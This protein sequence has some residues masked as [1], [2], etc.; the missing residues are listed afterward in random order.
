MKLLRPFSFLLVILLTVATLS[1]CDSAL[2]ATPADQVPRSQA[3]AS[4]RNA[5][6][7]LFGAY[8]ALQFSGVYGGPGYYAADFTT[9]NL[10]F[11]G[12]FT[13][14]QALE[15]FSVLSTL[16]TALTIYDDLYDAILRANGVIVGLEESGAINPDRAAQFQAEAKFIRALCYHN[17]LRW[18]AQ[19]WNTGGANDQLGVPLVLEPVTNPG[20]V[21]RMPRATVAE[22]YNQINTDLE[23]A[24]STFQQEGVSGPNTNG[25][26]GLGA[27]QALLARVRLYQARYESASELATSVIESGE[28]A[29]L[30]SVAALYGTSLTEEDVFAVVNT[31][32]DNSGTNSFPSSFYLP[33]ALGGRGDLIVTPELLSIYDDFEDARQRE[34]IYR[35]EGGSQVFGVPDSTCLSDDTDCW[36]D[37][38]R[39]PNFADN[40][41]VIRLAE[42]Y[43]IRAEAEARQDDG[44]EEQ[45]LADLNTIRTRA[46]LE[47]F[48]SVDDIGDGDG[49]D[50]DANED[51]TLISEIL[52][53]RRRELAFEGKYRHTLIRLGLPLVDENGGVAPDFQ[54]ILPIPSEAIDANPELVQNPGY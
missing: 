6:A 44:D 3:F 36:S 45:A 31:T 41:R 17:L 28:F 48:D 7:S 2:D 32:D 27:V 14:Y 50:S 1:A 39:D 51:G 13:T 21:E 26:A 29:L 47:A 8:S 23:E 12:S 20:E 11:V 40:I 42:M 54:R 49:D 22:V 30:G 46:G 53:E 34:L 15:N 24:I 9:T 16:G 37:K 18:F 43:L 38:Y 33:S 4:E 52:L 5:Q 25:R 19:P 35:V 10:N